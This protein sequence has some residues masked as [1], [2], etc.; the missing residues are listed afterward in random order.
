MTVRKAGWCPDSQYIIAD[1]RHG[2]RT[3]FVSI[4]TKS[5]T[6]TELAGIFVKRPDFSLSRDGRT[7]VYLGERLQ[8]ASDVWAL[9]IGKEPLR[10]TD[11]HPQLA[12]LNL[13]GIQE[14]SWKSSQDGL[15]LHGLVITPPDFETGKPRPT[16]VHVHGGPPWSWW[17]GWH[18]SWSLW[19]QLL[20][21]NGYAVF[22]PNPRGSTDQG[23]RFAQANL[24]DWGGGDF[25]DIMD[26]VEHIIEAGIADPDRLGVGGWSY[27]GYMSAWAV[28]Q[29]ERFQAAVVG[30]GITDLSSFHGT[31][32]INP[33]YLNIYFPVCSFP[34]RK[35]FSDHSPMSF[36]RACKT[37]T[38]VLHPV[39]DRRVPFGQ[40][41]Q[42][43]KGLRELGIETRMV[44][45]PRE[46]HGLVERT[47]QRD[48]LDR[49][50]A[51]FDRHLK[52][53][54]P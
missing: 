40:G 25:R 34:C 5:D 4:D 23:W 18:G 21:S 11:L 3:E 27:G 52:Y 45:Y 15:T 30:A 38:L 36:L 37:P 14:I 33:D 12:S 47:H 29:T 9:E 13:G 16:V 8:R 54:M 53:R 20:A 28:T 50:L 17:L 42:F 43:Y 32:D 7:I 49:V 39:E 22:L 44:A 6:M 2:V 24:N 35:T 19:G 41:L 51:W 46:G 31:T 48:V 1:C 26:G 10:L